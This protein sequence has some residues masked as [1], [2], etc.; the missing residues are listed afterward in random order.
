MG[1][2]ALVGTP[3]ERHIDRVSINED[4]CWIWGGDK[5]SHGY[6]RLALG[7]RRVQAHRAFY[8]V[9]IGPIPVP[10]VCDHLCRVKLCVNP[11]HIEPVPN[12]ENTVR[13][14]RAKL[15][16]E[17]IRF[18]RRDSRPNK[19]LGSILGVSRRTVWDVRAGVSWSHI[20]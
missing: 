5:S 3:L 4:G 17:A 7:G 14:R 20:Q 12:V 16:P 2:S 1:L 11:A 15:T 10:L 13:G 9:L 8:L 18:I 6:G 19:Q